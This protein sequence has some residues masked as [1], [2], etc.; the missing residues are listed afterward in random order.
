MLKKV[1]KQHG[2]EDVL[3][4]LEP[5]VAAWFGGKFSGLTE[6]QAYAVPLIHDRKNVLISSPT[7]SGKTLTAFLTIIN[8]LYRLQTR[9]EL[10]DRIYCVYVSPLK[11]L[12]NDINRNLRAPLQEM[13]ALAKE[14]GWDPPAI[15]VAVRSGDTPPSERQRQVRKPPHIFITTPE[16]LAIVLSTPKFRQR[17]QEVEWVIV[18]EIHE[19]CS[20]KRGAMLSVNLERLAEHV[21]QPFT[22]IGLSATI[23]PIRE[24]AR[25]LSGFE[26]GRMRP[27]HVVE[28]ESRKRLDLAVLCPVDDLTNYAMEEAN[29]RMYNLL[30]HEIDRHRTTLIFTNTRSGTEHVAFKLKERGVEDLEAHHGS[31]SKVTRLDVEERL[32]RGEL[33]AAVSST[34]LELG[35]DIGYIDLVVQIGSPKSVAKGL[36]RIGRAGH[37]YGE[38]SKGRMVVFEPW[39]LMECAALAKAAYDNRIDR[40]DIVRNALDVL[41]QT[42]VG[43]ALERRWDVDDAYALVRRSYTFH[44]LPRRDFLA[45]L[46]YLSSRN[47]NIRVYAKLWYDPEEGRFGRKR[48]ARMIYYTNVGTIPEEGTY[49]VFSERGTPLGDLSEHFVEYLEPGDVFVLGARTYEFVRARGTTV[50]VKDAAGRRPTVPSWQGEMLPRSYDLSRQVGKFRRD[51]A[52]TIDREG[53]EA[54]LAWLVDHYRVDEGSARSLISYIQEQRALVAHLPTDRQVLLEGYVDVKGNRNAIFHFPFGRRVNDALSRVYAFALSQK[55]QC[56]VRVAVTDDNFMLTVPKRVALK[57]LETLVGSKDL[58]PLLRRAVRNTELFKQRF[59]HCATRSFMVLRSYKGREVSIGRQQLRSQRVLDFL[60]EIEDFPVIKETYNEILHEVMDVVHAKEVLRMMEKGEIRV[61][62][63]GWS[64]VPTPFAHNAVLV[65][66]SDIVLMEDRSALLRDL[67]R[68]I[69]RRVV[70]LE[71]MEKFQFAEDRV[72]DHFR[73]KVPPVQT[74]GDLLALLKRFGALNLLQQKGRNVYDRSDVPFR[75]V[76]MWAQ[77]LMDEDAV[78]SVWTPR[79]VLYAARGDVPTYAAVYRRGA[80]LR[81]EERVVLDALRRKPQSA[82]E[83]QGKTKLDRRT[84]LDILRKLERTYAVHRKGVDPVVFHARSVSR[85]SFEDA[86]DAL[87]VRHLDW[88]GPT[89][90]HELAYFLGLEEA[91]VGEALRDLENEDTVRSGHFVLGKD[92]EYMLAKDFDALQ[93]RGEARP[94][95]DEAVARSFVM[96]KQLTPLPSIDAYFDRFGEAGMV[97]DVFN[98]VGDFRMEE[99]LAK[100]QRGEILEGR[101]LNGRVRY[102]RAKDAPLYVSAF[103]RD[104]LNVFERKIL[105]LLR[106]ENGM[107]T[108]AVVA[109]AGEDRDLVK[110]ALDKLDANC[111]VIR[112]FTGDDGWTSRNVYVGYDVVEAV[113]DAEAT[114]VRRFLRAYGPTT[115]S[116]IKEYTRFRWDDLER[117][118]ERLEKEGDVVRVLLSGRG[119]TEAYVLADEV[120]RLRRHTPRPPEDTRILS[121]LDPWVQPLWAQIAARHGEGWFFP[122]IRRGELVGV[123]EMW[124]MSGCIEVRGID[125]DDPTHLADALD[126]LDRMMDFY[127]QR[128]YDILRLTRALGTDVPDLDDLTPFLRVGYHRVG[129]FLAKGR[130]RPVEFDEERLMAYVLWRQGIPPDRRF[131]TTRDAVV[132]LGGLRSDFAARLRCRDPAGLERLHRKG[133]L[134]AG[135]AIPPYRTYCTEADLGLY[136]R[137]KDAPLSEDMEA[138]LAVVE[139][140]GPVSRTQILALAAM[141]HGTAAAALKRLY[142]GSYVARDARGLYRV[143]PDPPFGVE[144]ARRTVLRRI[145]A[146]YGVF[147]AENLAQYT[148]FAFN[149]AE[150]RRLLRAFED[151][152]WLVKGFFRRGDRRPHWMVKEDVDRVA[153]IPFDD[154][155]VLTPLDNLALYL[156]EDVART[157]RMGTCYVVFDGPRMVGAFRAQR[158]RGDLRVTRFEGSTRARE[159]LQ[160]FEAEN[161]LRVDEEVDRISD[162]EIMEWYAKMYARGSGK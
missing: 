138:V 25:F 113:P 85:G 35:I 21:G 81:P 150:I 30:A 108:N 87:I 135:L 45:T 13:E 38:T 96:E 119:E 34:S 20:S 158:R 104:P 147:T 47:P 139:E 82:K 83:L 67:H 105:T 101:F 88:E 149:M 94:V 26:G 93:R 136:K 120:E 56:N 58:V 137:A 145:V 152:G 54:A 70:P 15:R 51:L 72:R 62:R 24:V 78:Q 107:D 43:M 141:D 14:E 99:W 49:H 74:K 17:F 95:I 100:R 7:G 155:F 12:A 75:Q 129:D 146:S 39:D 76:R 60:H 22:R 98:H 86:L 111:Y 153:D 121:L 64:N 10:E 157:W 115:F 33:K 124:P 63:T 77:E 92:Y 110:E 79:G 71:E 125:L 127:R 1:T 126:A 114:L 59:R 2:K 161:D 27:M 144:E 32:K 16:S 65:G 118:M 23:A 44:T 154:A 132:A 66:M 37:A 140:E 36:Q 97:L 128:G 52:A 42:L 69:L 148:R 68:E 19:I 102:V 109:G 8:E 50:Y 160:T 28:V 156:R 53:E 117:L 106:K 143:V 29:A 89:T 73:R 91:I 151:E 133:V 130:F 84:V 41:A 131:A 5:L 48:G 3:A 103:R 162:H 134:L 80:R 122:V 123:V 31:L 142:A 159:I 57:G 9:G 46:D 55:L 18:D 90:L 112:K 116:H 40:V 4:L 11:A 61:K 6:P